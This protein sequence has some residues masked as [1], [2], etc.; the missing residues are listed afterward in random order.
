MDL[1]TFILEILER[2]IDLNIVFIFIFD[3]IIS[4]STFH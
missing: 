2:F 3:Y 4:Q 1:N